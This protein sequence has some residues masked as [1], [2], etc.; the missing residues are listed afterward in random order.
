[1]SD[2][3]VN[4]DSFSPPRKRKTVSGEAL[5]YT[6]TGTRLFFSGAASGG[7][8]GATGRSL[9]LSDTSSIIFSPSHLTIPK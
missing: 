6:A 5:C 7:V 9:G 2:V 1:M 4:A 3:A 8:A